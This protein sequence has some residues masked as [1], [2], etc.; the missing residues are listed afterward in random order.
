MEV[1]N[2]TKNSR[3]PTYMIYPRF[4][5]EMED[6][7][8]TAK[9]VYMHLLDRA[10]LSMQREDWI[11]EQGYVF[12]NYTIEN[13]SKAL[14]KSQTTVKT[15]LKALEQAKLITR[16]RQGTCRPSRIY[17][18]LPKSESCPNN[19]QKSGCH[20]GRNPPASKIYEQYKNYQYED[21]DSL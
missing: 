8:D 11:D 18:K 20:L 1:S 13:L 3:M 7:P 2:L 19:R 15:S 9:I 10:R 17:V 6:L 5:A 21:G 12:L 14:H 16:K 4:L